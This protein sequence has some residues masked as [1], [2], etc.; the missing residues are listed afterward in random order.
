ML[1]RVGGGGVFMRGLGAK[2]ARVM[3]PLAEE[4]NQTIQEHSPS[5]FELLSQRGRALYFPRGILSQTA[6]AK[7]KAHRFNATIGEATEGD[8]PMALPSILSHIQGIAPSDALGRPGAP[9]R[10]LDG[11]AQRTL[12]DVRCLRV[13]VAACLAGE[14][15]A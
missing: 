8:A 7:A 10:R 15:T 5:V 11:S 4:L 9:S 3:N 6:E 13:L 1:A 14:P 2:L 12:R